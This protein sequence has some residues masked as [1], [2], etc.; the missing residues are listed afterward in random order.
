MHYQNTTQAAQ[1]IYDAI[2]NVDPKEDIIDVDEILEIL[3]EE[4]LDTYEL[5][6]Q[7]ED[8]KTLEENS[9]DKHFFDKYFKEK[10]DDYHNVL[11]DI[12]NEIIS[13]YLLDE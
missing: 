9:E 2:K 1:Y 6:L 8:L 13:G 12:V 10:F 3:Q 7:P 4:I 11:T 5:E